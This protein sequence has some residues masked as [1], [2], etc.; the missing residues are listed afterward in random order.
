VTTH[1]VEEIQN[2]LTDVM[3]IHRGRIVLN[4]SMEEFD[5]RYLEVMVHPEHLAAARALRPMHERQVFGRSI[6]L[7]IV[8]MVGNSPA[9]AKCERRASP[10]CSLRWWVIRPAGRKERRGEY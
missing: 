3:F 7:S 1:Q 2:V 9:S 10:I 8:S 4:S 6:M 5:A